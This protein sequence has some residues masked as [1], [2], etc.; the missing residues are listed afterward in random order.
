MFKLLR[1]TPA[2]ICD[3]Y[4]YETLPRRARSPRDSKTRSS[5][6]LNRRPAVKLNLK[7]TAGPARR[8]AAWPGNTKVTVMELL[9]TVNRVTVG[10][11]TNPAVG[12]PRPAAAAAAYAIRNET[13]NDG[14]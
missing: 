9:V 11:G 4:A 10:Y 1:G 12:G 13:S 3:C 8:R 7:F 2:L 6:L 5:S 14:G